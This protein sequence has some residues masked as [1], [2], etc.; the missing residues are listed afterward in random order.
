[1][2]PYSSSVP[3]RAQFQN[4]IVGVDFSEAS[5][6]AVSVGARVAAGVAA[7]LTLAH[8]WN[9]AYPYATFS[10][11]ALRA[12]IE[13]SEG[14]LIELAHAAER[15]GVR[16]VETVF[17]VGRPADAITRLVRED[18]SYGLIVVGTHGRTGL[19]HVLLGSVAEKLVRTSPCPVLVVPTRAAR[20]ARGDE[21]RSSGARRTQIPI[22]RAD[23]DPSRR[24]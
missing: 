9:V 16:E 11:D 23:G 19:A 4:I 7:S 22:E 2:T 6:E 21:T 18:S 1:M 3:D 5:S 8:V 24:R 14:A 17:L 15:E 13:T 20:I 10:D 12:A